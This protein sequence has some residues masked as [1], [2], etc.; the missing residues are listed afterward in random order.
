MRT[1]SYTSVWSVLLVNKHG[2][3]NKIIA[4]I[5]TGVGVK[6]QCSGKYKSDLESYQ[7]ER[8]IDKIKGGQVMSHKLIFTKKDVF[9]FH[10]TLS[11]L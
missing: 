7:S 9:Y 5:N 4:R 11:L 3:R 1:Y 2:D 10:Y 8:E 6:P